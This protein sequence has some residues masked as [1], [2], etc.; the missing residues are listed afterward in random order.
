MSPERQA[1][2]PV[3]TPRPQ[4]VRAERAD[5]HPHPAGQPPP[6][7]PARHEQ[8]RQHPL[9]AKAGDACRS[10]FP[11]GSSV[12]GENLPSPQPC[13]NGKR[14][15]VS[16]TGRT[17]PPACPPRTGRTRYRNTG[18]RPRIPMLRNACRER[19][20]G[21]AAPEF[22]PPFPAEAGTFVLRIVPSRSPTSFL[23]TSPASRVTRPTGEGSRR[24]CR[25]AASSSPTQ[26]EREQASPS[27][28]FLRR[29]SGPP[30]PRQPGP[31]EC[32]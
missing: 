23:L 31:P 7:R 4:P 16:Y 6:R 32:R 2:E 13:R 30:P 1:A 28:N 19:Q 21:S 14:E 25:G 22:P 3:E 12:R 17:P 27:R 26:S 20:R 8:C 24:A 15:A 5:L 9:A 11:D 18:R 29:I 10:G